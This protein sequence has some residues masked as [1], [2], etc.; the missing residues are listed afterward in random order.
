MNPTHHP[1]PQPPPP[2]LLAW[3]ERVL[4]RAGFSPELATALASDGAYDLHETLKLLRRRCPPPVAARILAPVS[5]REGDR[6]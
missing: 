6:E 5:P 1:L 3:R 2:S 4:R